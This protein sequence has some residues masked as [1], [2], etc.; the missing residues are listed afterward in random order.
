MSMDLVRVL[1][2]GGMSKYLLAALLKNPAFKNH[3][4][5]YV[6]GTT[7]L[8]LSKAALHEYSLILPEDIS[9]LSKVSDLFES[10][11]RSQAILIDETRALA[12]TR[13]A[14]LPKLMSGE[15]DVEKVKVA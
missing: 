12:A 5:R 13:D 10:V 3:C 2:K 7:V 6:N 8:H 14:L 11:Y 9:L 4:L 15:I 1:P